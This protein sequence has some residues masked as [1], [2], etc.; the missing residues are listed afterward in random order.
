MFPSQYLISVGRQYCK[1]LHSCFALRKNLSYKMNTSYYISSLKIECMQ[2]SGEGGGI[3]PHKVFSLPIALNVNRS[4]SNFLTFKFH[5]RGIIR[6][7]IKF[8]SCQGS[9]DQSFVG[10]TLLHRIFQCIYIEFL[11]K[12]YSIYI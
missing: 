3:Y 6:Q 4:T 7:N 1:I 12:F 5:C 8:K 2:H 9:R 11:S 10:S